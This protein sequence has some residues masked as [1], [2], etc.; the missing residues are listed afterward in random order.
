MDD[1][2]KARFCCGLYVIRQLLMIQKYLR[3][4]QS[5]KAPGT[6]FIKASIKIKPGF[7]M[8]NSGVVCRRGEIDGRVWKIEPSYRGHIDF[9]CCGFL[10]Y[11]Q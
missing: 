6:A 1:R 3:K 10:F 7:F 11:C 9:S 8:E 5:G 4:H 2:C